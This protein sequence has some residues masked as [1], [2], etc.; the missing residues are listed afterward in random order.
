MIETVVM[1][2]NW[3]DGLTEKQRRF[4]EAY[5]ANGGNA[6]DA[7]R[8]AGYA[9]PHPQGAENLQK[10]TI[11]QALELLRSEKT[12]AAIATREE[13]QSF[14]TSVMRDSGQEMKD[15]LRA[16]ELLGK[17]HADF[18]DR[19]EHSGP[20]GGPIRTAADLTDEQLAAIASTGR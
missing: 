12:N 14:W 8:V 13:R 3:H 16:A 7:A 4:C 1:D 10:P 11:L 9:K 19:H 20:N 5:A 15:R 18:L 6:L 2:M 17:A